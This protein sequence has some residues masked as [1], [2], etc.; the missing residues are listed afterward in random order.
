[1]YTRIFDALNYRKM[2]N[3]LPDKAFLKIN[4][5]LEIMLEKK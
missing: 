5:W 4:I 2:L 3:W 1:M